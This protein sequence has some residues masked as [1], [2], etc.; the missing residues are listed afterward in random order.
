[1]NRAG[2]SCEDLLFLPT[3]L[4]FSYAKYF[5]HESRAFSDAL[6]YTDTQSYSVDSF[7]SFV[8]L[9]HAARPINRNLKYR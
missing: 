2:I 4:L 9:Y 1:L 3:I 8:Y 6:Q 5:F 7:I